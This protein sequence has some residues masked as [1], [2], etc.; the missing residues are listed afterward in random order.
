MTNGS[1]DVE[2][3]AMSPDGSTLISGGSDKTIK[4]W[5]LASGGLQRALAGYKSFSTCLAL[6]PDGKTL[7]SSSWYKETVK[8]G[9]FETGEVKLGWVYESGKCRKVNSL[10]ISPDGKTLYIGTKDGS[11][12]YWNINTGKKL[13]NL[14]TAS[15][16]SSLLARSADGRILAGTYTGTFIVRSLPERKRRFRVATGHNSP[17]LAI[18]PDGETVF[19]SDYDGNIHLWDSHQGKELLALGGHSGIVTAIGVSPDGHLL[20]SGDERGIIKL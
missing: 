15:S 9:N 8:V 2:A 16:E 6:S 17:S 3:I 5:N 7:V 10:V 1:D 18:S 4:V 12:Y 20:T 14:G 11:T 13:G 19:I